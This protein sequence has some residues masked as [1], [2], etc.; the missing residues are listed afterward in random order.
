MYFAGGL[1]HGWFWLVG[2]T[3]TSTTAKDLTLADPL[4]TLV[5]SAIPIPFAAFRPLSP[6]RSIG[7]AMHEAFQRH[8]EQAGSATSTQ[9]YGFPYTCIFAV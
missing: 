9:E 5:M 7:R 1:L 8:T 3:A 4:T 2:G 6:K